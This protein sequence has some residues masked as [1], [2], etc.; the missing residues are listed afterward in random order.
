MIVREHDMGLV[1]IEQHE[2]GKLA[3][4][5]AKQLSSAVLAPD[6]PYASDLITAIYEH[7]RGWIY[8]DKKPLWNE[9]TGK[10]YTFVDYPLE[11]KLA[12]YQQGLDEVE[13]MSP[14]ASLICSMHFASFTQQAHET[15]WKRFLRHEENRQ[16]RLRREL[17]LEAEHP[18]LLRHFRL[19][20]LCD[21]LSL[22]VCLNEP[23]AD[24]EAEHPWFR[25]GF[26]HTS[27]LNPAEDTPVTAYWRERE[28]VEVR[29]FLF[30]D[31]FEVSVTYRKL[32]KERVRLMGGEAAYKSSSP[33]TGLLRIQ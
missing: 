23:G 11:P 3:G 32:A 4:D 29:P 28:F 33:R 5:F 16:D 30:S 13:D 8:L 14:Y 21:D 7:D 25:D 9:E 26:A 1:M 12:A 10:P 20:Q 15:A 18:A 19:L 22:Y 17:G 6:E 2:H 27:F 24:K 31:P